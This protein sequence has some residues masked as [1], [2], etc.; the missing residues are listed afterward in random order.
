MKTY[1]NKS[2]F[3]FCNWDGRISAIVNNIG[4]RIP[5]T[6]IEGDGIGAE[7]MAAATRVLER[8]VEKA[9][10]GRKLW[11][12]V[13]RWRWAVTLFRKALSTPSVKTKWR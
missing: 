9:W 3:Y 6:V 12:A 4:T 11:R 2:G 13:R 5:V 7:I 10:S 1:Q 8:A